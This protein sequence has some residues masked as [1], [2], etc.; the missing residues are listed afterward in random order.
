MSTQLRFD[1]V[2][3]TAAIESGD[4]RY[5]C[6]LYSDQAEVIVVRAGADEPPTVLAGKQAIQQW[7]E[8]LNA[9]E[10]VHQVV[11]SRADGSLFSL[12]DHFRHPDGRES[13]YKSTA[14]VHRGQI[15]KQTVTVVWEDVAF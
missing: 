9:A 6:A 13:V 3:L 8:Q 11:E 14:K 7:V 2:G 10:A 15:V 4:A 12:T 1:L 5:Q